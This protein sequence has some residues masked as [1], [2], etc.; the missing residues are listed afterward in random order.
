VIGSA[1]A[2]R[3]E[4]YSSS[5]C[6]ACAHTRQ[7]LGVALAAVE[8]ITV[9]EFDVA[10]DP[11]RAEAEGID[12]TPTVIVRDAAGAEVFRAPGVPTLDQVL[13]AAVLA[14]ESSTPP[15]AHENLDASAL[16]A[17]ADSDGH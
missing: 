2:V 7:I 9:R 17:E 15:D 4:L 5:F 16:S 14:R 11:G 8:G 3:F 12:A 6:G 13:A 1:P 10:F